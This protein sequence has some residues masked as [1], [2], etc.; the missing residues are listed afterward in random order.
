MEF[1]LTDIK[2]HLTIEQQLKFQGTAKINL[3]DIATHP[4]VDREVDQKNVEQL[5]E[6]FAKDGCQRLDI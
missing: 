6:I 3:N 5:C 4:G 2:Q 1:I